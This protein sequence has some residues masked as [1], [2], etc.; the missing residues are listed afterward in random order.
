LHMRIQ[1]I[2]MVNCKGNTLDMRGA[3]G[4]S[5]TAGG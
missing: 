4:L 2:Q 1:A 3:F 5:A